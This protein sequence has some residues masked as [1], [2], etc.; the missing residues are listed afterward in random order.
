MAR[1]SKSA[2]DGAVFGVLFLLVL[3]WLSPARTRAESPERG[4]SPPNLLILI[5]DDLAA[6]T[7]GIDGNSR[8]ATP[9]I[10][11]LA[12]Q[13]VW[14]A[15][16]YCNSPV[17]TA[18]R[19]S[20]IT[21]KLPHAVGVTRLPTP[22]P[23]S[24][25]TLGD[26]LSALGYETAAYGKMHFNGPSPHGFRERLD[27]SDWQAHLKAH[28]P[29]GGDQRKPWRPFR[30]PAAVWLNAACE[31][32]GLPES[33]M[34]TTYYADRAIEFF[35]RPHDRPFALIVSAYDPH[36]PFRFPS[37]WEGR[38]RPDQFETP[39]M[40]DLD[41]RERPRVFQP[42]TPDD[43]RGIQAAYYT[44]QAYLDH[45]WGRILEALDGSK[46]GANTLVVCLGDN[47]YLLG[48]HGR[49]EKHCFYEQAV[50]VP[51]I[52]RWPG[53]VPQG[54]RIDDLVEMVDVLPTVLHLL[55]LPAPPDLQGHDLTDLIGGRSGAHGRDVVFSEYLE[56]EEAMVRSDRYKLIVGTGQRV[57][58]DG[59]ETDNPL[60]GPYERLY[61][62]TADP[63]ET[64]NVADRAGL[65][66][67]KARLLRHLYQ[68]LVTT[69]AGLEPIPPGLSPI[70]AVR[71]CL[72]P[73][74]L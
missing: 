21:G 8:A 27:R 40:T 56:N 68:R 12:H 18:S 60:P 54:R 72:V 71:R 4:A 64:T 66:E 65:A 67:V 22:L 33:A 42:L 45:Q 74:D 28:P 46:L 25:L 53:H 15:R 57:R 70:E 43:L 34:E 63:A 6:W 44:S 41:R 31:S 37:G 10:D 5:G 30:D 69:R 20:L 19:Q 58:Q 7:L 50:R 16:A 11:A 52:L 1:G 26:W 48:Q 51:W 59:Y 32:A 38:F 23:D 61:D 17:C 14:F 49:A 62:L 13:G 24:A 3:S 39:E 9:R 55:G 36:S 73:P 35:Q 47:G 2:W 29:E